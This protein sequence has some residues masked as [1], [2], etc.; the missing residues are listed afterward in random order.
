MRQDVDETLEVNQLEL[1]R[2]ASTFSDHGARA[3]FQENLE[4]TV[5]SW[6]HEHPGGEAA[7][8]KHTEHHFV[9]L[10]FERFWNIVVQEQVTCESLSDVLVSLRACLNGVLL[11]TLRTSSRPGTIS[12][13]ESAEQNQQ[14]P[15]QS[16]EV[17]KW[18]QAKLCNERKQR[19]AYLLYHCGLEPREIVQCS[20]QEWSDVQEV[21]R[22]RRSIFA[23]LMNG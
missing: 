9:A 15:G 5:L 11:E 16:L 8:R 14:C 19:L 6:F 23:R 13:F 1:L 10:A 7:C 17:W 22:L 3:T 20:P 12:E 2:R 18:V 21:M 4:G